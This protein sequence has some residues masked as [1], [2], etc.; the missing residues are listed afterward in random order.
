MEVSVSFL[1]LPAP[2]FLKKKSNQNVMRNIVEDNED[3]FCLNLKLKGGGC[4]ERWDF[5]NK[6]KTS[7]PRHLCST[8]LF[9]LP[10]DLSAVWTR[11]ERERQRDRE[12]AH[13]GANV[14]RQVSRLSSQ[15]KVA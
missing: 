11:P 8:L 1:P 15:H 3:N 5:V 9:Q 12:S 10:S 2:S 14:T 6:R 7:R 13:A 4:D